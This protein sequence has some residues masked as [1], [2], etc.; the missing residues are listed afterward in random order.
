MGTGIIVQQDHAVS[1]FTQTF[2]LDLVMQLLKLSIVSSSC[3]FQQLNI[4]P[5]QE[6]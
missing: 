4:L 5:L 2:I 3:E 1:E 6:T